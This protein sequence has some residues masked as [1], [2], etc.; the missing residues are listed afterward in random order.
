M[1]KG[2]KLVN[3]SDQKPGKEGKV[4]PCELHILGTAL[5]PGQSML[6]EEIAGAVK[7]IVEEGYLLDFIEMD[8]N[9]GEEI[10]KEPK[11]QDAPAPKKER[12]EPKNS[13]EP[14]ETNPKKENK[15]S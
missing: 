11:K 7:I 6:V 9:T 2:Y 15:S 10:N 12:S 1:K 8:L 5:A 4:E 14:E 3:I 13:P